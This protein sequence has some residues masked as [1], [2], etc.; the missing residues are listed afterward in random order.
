MLNAGDAEVTGETLL[1]GGSLRNSFSGRLISVSCIARGTGPIRVQRCNE[2]RASWSLGERALSHPLRFLSKATL[3]LHHCH[4]YRRRTRRPKRAMSRRDT[5]RSVD[6]SSTS[7]PHSTKALSNTSR[8]KS[9]ASDSTA[10]AKR[11]APCSLKHL[12]HAMKP[13]HHPRSPSTLGER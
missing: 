8:N 7:K 4:P 6:T 1:S 5:Q 9:E 11:S 13:Q 2:H 10:T 12:T 3:L